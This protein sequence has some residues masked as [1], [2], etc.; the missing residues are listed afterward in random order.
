MARRSQRRDAMG[1]EEKP[2]SGPV[3]LAGLIKRQPVRN[4]GNKSWRPLQLSDFGDDENNNDADESDHD[5]FASFTTLPDPVHLP[6]SVGDFNGQVVFIGHPNRDV[7]AHQWALDIFQWTN[8]GL[9]SH[10]RRRIEGSLASDRLRGS[11]I[12]HNTIHYFKA[13]AEQREKQ[14]QDASRSSVQEASSE[15]RR[16]H[17]TV[18]MQVPLSPE[19]AHDRQK[20]KDKLGELCDSA[21]RESLPVLIPRPHSHQAPAK[22]LQPPPGF[23]IAKP[24]QPPPGFTIANPTRITSKLNANA[25]PYTH[26]PSHELSE[27]SESEATAVKGQPPTTLEITDPDDLRHN[28]ISEPTKG[29]SHQKPTPQNFKGPFFTDPKPLPLDSTTPLPPTN[30]EEGKLM[31]W[32]RDGQRPARQQEFCRKIMD[33]ADANIQL[34]SAHSFGAIGDVRTKHR[35]AIVNTP[36]FVS[37]YENLSGYLEESKAGGGKDHF[38]R[39]WK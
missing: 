22:P 13:V 30:E 16:P 21:R 10:N 2:T 26:L 1:G 5:E 7:S 9:Y 12:P 14:V 19:D 31:N 11:N 38:T 39:R 6:A 18:R 27:A 34:R 37:L 24:L 4:K 17:G 8:I 3:S 28:P 25:T 23:T 33:S 15:N 35:G 36:L 29:L 20:L 32:F